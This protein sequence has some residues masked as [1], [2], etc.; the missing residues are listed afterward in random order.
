MIYN[1]NRWFARTVIG[2]AILDAFQKELPL[3]L[4]MEDHFWYFLQ[5]ITEKN[6]LIYIFTNLTS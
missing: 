1:K 2:S 3:I 5:A 6:A 4:Y